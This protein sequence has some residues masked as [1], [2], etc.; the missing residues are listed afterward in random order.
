[1]AKKR[2]SKA[3]AWA[4]RRYSNRG[5][6]YARAKGFYGK[7]GLTLNAPF[8]AGAAAAFVLPENEM[9]TVGGLLG[10]TAPV[11]G[12]GPVKGAAQ[13]YIFGQV[14]QK[15]VLPKLG[16]NIGNIMGQGNNSYPGS[17]II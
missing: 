13:G 12:L 4:G 1:M 8:M 17:N 11:K 6:Y 9:L 15:Y 7:T 2:F 10:A 14:L 5:A 16:V 3:R